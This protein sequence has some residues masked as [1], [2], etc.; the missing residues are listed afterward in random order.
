MADELPLEVELVEPVEV[1]LLVAVLRS[2]DLL[3]E[4]AAA[5]A[6]LVAVALLAAAE[7]LTTPWLV[8]PA[9]A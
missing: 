8:W 1:E 6:S 7:P 3:P 5:E 2:V 9:L 4:A